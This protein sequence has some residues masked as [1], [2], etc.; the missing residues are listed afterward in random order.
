[1]KVAPITLSDMSSESILKQSWCLRFLTR[2]LQRRRHQ[3]ISG[4]PHLN[5]AMNILSF[6]LN[7]FKRKK[8]VK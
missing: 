8:V 5:N 1:M 3:K 6:Q 7:L 2:C 4:V